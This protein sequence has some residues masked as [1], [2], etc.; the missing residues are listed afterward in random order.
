M[1]AEFV[2]SPPLIAVCSTVYFASQTKISPGI[3][4]VCEVFDVVANF[5]KNNGYPSS[6]LNG[7]PFDVIVSTGGFG[8]SKIALP[9]FS[10]FI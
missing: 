8:T 10:T 6:K 3:N 2:I 7:V 5:L 1:V 9:V 4:L